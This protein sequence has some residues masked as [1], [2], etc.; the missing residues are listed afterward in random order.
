M[1]LAEKFR[2]PFVDLRQQKGS[3]KVFSLLPPKL[4]QKLKVLPLSVTEGTLLIATVLPEPKT[5][6]EIILKYSPVKDIAFVLAQ[7]S[8]LKNVIKMLFQE[9]K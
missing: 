1:A 8:H 2:I 3:K 5:I 9:K 6:C 7:P 4:I